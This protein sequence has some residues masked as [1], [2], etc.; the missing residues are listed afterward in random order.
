MRWTSNERCNYVYEVILKDQVKY[1]F[2]ERIMDGWI[3]SIGPIRQIDAN[4]R[5][6]SRKDVT[7]TFQ[8][9]T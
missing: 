7:V 1:F 4:L 9:L 2:L 5:W 6:T 8:G 3:R